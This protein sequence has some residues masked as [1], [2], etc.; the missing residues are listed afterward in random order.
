MLAIPGLIELFGHLRDDRADRHNV[1]IAEG[2]I[3][4]RVEILV[5]DDEF[6]SAPL[7]KT[8]LGWNPPAIDIGAERCWEEDVAHRC[9]GA[10]AAGEASLKV[11]KANIERLFDEARGRVRAWKKAHVS[12][13]AAPSA[14]GSGGKP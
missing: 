3:R 4:V 11:R 14:D 8:G 13:A 7:F 2:E 5:G 1:G 10:G 6:E 12:V 9:H